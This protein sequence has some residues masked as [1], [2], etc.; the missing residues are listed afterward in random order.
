VPGKLIIAAKYVQIQKL[1]VFSGF[2]REVEENCAL[3]DY[4]AASSGNF[5]PTFRDNVLVPSS[6][7]KN[8]KGG[9]FTFEGA[10]DMLSRNVGKK[11]PLLAA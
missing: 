10:I 2:R 9:F 5:L 4:D 1:C 7:V 6:E 11:L 8:P 3:L